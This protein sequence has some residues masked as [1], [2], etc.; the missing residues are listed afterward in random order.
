MIA[1]FGTET[2][3]RDPTKVCVH[4]FHQPAVCGRIPLAPR[5]EP[6][7]HVILGH[8]LLR[9]PSVQPPGW[10]ATDNRFE[11]GTLHFRRADDRPEPISIDV[12]REGGLVCH[13]RRDHHLGKKRGDIDA[14]RCRVERG[15]TRWGRALQE[16]LCA[17]PNEIAVSEPV[18]TL[19]WRFA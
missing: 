10:R 2:P 6:P 15:E 17:L 7:G 18:A 14:C 9:G 8:R 13:Q 12:V 16:A 1:A 5:H 11:E 3:A 19:P 4:G